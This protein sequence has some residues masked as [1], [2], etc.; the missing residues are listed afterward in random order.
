M[1]VVFPR[2]SFTVLDA[3]SN[4]LLRKYD[5]AL[6]DV[7]AGRQALREK[8]ASRTLPE[9]LTGLFERA[10]TNLSAELEAIKQ[11][12]EKL[13]PTLV[14][15][16]ANSEQKMQYQLSNLERKASA[17]V[18]KRSD[19]VEKDALR[20]E[21][22]LYPEKSLQERFYGGVSLL[23][24]FGAPLLDQLYESISLDSSDHKVIAP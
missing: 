19:Q 23:G 16:A 13:D 8:M 21:N 6:A 5:L 10:T 7:F 22:S 3:T 18:Q 15:A 1:P 20:L 11:Q 14:D 24:R 12:L 9:G 2:A 4:R 17:A